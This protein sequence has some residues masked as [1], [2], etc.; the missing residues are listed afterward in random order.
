MDS[1]DFE[2][3][4]GVDSGFVGSEAYIVWVFLFKKKTTKLGIGPH[5]VPKEVRGLKLKLK[6]I[7]NVSLSTSIDR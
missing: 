6:T 5:L 3:H 2:H 1:H 4:P 7:V